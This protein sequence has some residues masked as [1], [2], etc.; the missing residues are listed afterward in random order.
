MGAKRLDK[1]KYRNTSFAQ[2]LPKLLIKC[3]NDTDLQDRLESTLVFNLSFEMRP[4]YF[5]W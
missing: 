1:Q 5:E 3:T 4:N 2:E